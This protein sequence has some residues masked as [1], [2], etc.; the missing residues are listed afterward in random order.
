MPKFSSAKLGLPPLYKALYY[1]SLFWLTAMMYSNWKLLTL[2]R[3]FM[4]ASALNVD[5]IVTRYYRASERQQDVHAKHTC[6]NHSCTMDLCCQLPSD[7]Q[8]HPTQ[9]YIATSRNLRTSHTHLCLPQASKIK[10]SDATKGLL[11][12]LFLPEIKDKI[13]LLYPVDS[14]YVSI[15][16]VFFLSDILSTRHCTSWNLL[17]SSLFTINIDAKWQDLVCLGKNLRLLTIGTLGFYL[18]KRNQ[19]WK[20]RIWWL[21]GFILSV[22]M[23]AWKTCLQIRGPNLGCW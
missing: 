3:Q 19:G 1:E 17:W 10:L 11:Y 13:D 16:Q 22:A 14:A 21:N 12:F 15:L 18:E 7:A 4:Y 2:P 9:S 5:K 23:S 20:S 6:M 8:T